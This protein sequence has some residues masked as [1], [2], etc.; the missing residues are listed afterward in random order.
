MTKAHFSARRILP[1]A[2]FLEVARDQPEDVSKA[3]RGDDRTALARNVSEAFSTPAGREVLEHLL[4]ITLRADFP[5]PMGEMGKSCEALALATAFRKGQN[6]IAL[7]LL[8]LMDE[9]TGEQPFFL[10]NPPT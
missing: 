7:H 9:A 8:R 3:V 5:H 4:D 6:Q 1:A 10:T 2:S